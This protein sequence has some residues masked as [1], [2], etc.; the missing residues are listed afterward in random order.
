MQWTYTFHGPAGISVVSERETGLCVFSTRSAPLAG[1][2]SSGLH[3]KR[4][5]KQGTAILNSA[6]SPSTDNPSLWHLKLQQAPRGQRKLWKNQRPRPATKRGGGEGKKVM[7]STFTKW[8]SKSTP[9]PV[10]PQRP[11]RSWTVLSTTSSSALPLRHLVLPTTTKDPPSLAERYRPPYVSCYLE[12]WPSTPWAK[13][14]KPSPSTPAANKSAC[15][16]HFPK[17]LFRANQI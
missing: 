15:R 7:E 17:A 6:L 14:R 11:C 10:Y 3:I 9:T 2:Q 12:N 13:A 16:F 4:R 1:Y 5:R 8:W